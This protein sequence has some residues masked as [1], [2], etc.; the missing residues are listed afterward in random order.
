MAIEVGSLL[1]GR[2]TGI[3]RFGAF[4]ELAEGV[5]GLVHISE[6]DDAYVVDIHDFLKVGDVVKVK[7]LRVEPGGKIALSIRQAKPG[8][9]PQRPRGRKGDRQLGFEDKLNRFLKDSEERLRSLR[10]SLDP[11]RGGRGSRRP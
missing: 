7:V 3:T 11:K 1:E 2:V 5:T 10:R 6:V 8:A 9:S 4:V